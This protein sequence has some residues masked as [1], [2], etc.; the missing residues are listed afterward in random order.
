MRE[1]EEREAK[2]IWRENKQPVGFIKTKN[3]RSLRRDI[4]LYATAYSKV[5][6]EKNFPM[7]RRRDLRHGVPESMVPV[8]LFFLKHEFGPLTL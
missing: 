6:N 8:F 7:Q 4:R 3:L 1:G 2:S 5:R